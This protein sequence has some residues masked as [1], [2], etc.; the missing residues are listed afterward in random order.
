MSS[1]IKEMN[2]LLD[3]HELS[4]NIGS[5]D[6]SGFFNNSNHNEAYEHGREFENGLKSKEKSK[7]AF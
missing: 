1:F 5:N 4:T 6:N 3:S 7:P 2:D